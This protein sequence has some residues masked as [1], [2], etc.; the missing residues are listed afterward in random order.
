M[1]THFI[2]M[3]PFCHEVGCCCPEQ[4]HQHMI[5]FRQGDIWTITNNRKYV[6]GLG[7]Y[8]LIDINNEFQFFIYV[9]DIQELHAKGSICSIW[10]L[11][12]KINYLNFK[13][14]K[15]LDTYDREA[16]LSLSN[17]L[18]HTQQVKSKMNYAHV[19]NV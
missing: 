11:D 18:R 3:K 14:N 19:Q 10:D 13:I 2:I 17:E 7:W 12:L 16:F 5:N 9:D 1:D 15:A 4:Q 6:D 8:C